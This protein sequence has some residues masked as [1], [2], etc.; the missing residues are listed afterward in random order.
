MVLHT[1]G[2]KL[3]TIINYYVFKSVFKSFLSLIA[4]NASLIQ[5]FFWVVMQSSTM[6]V[7]TLKP[8]MEKACA[9]R[10]SRCSLQ[11]IVHRWLLCLLYFIVN[12][13]AKIKY[14]HMF[15]TSFSISLWTC[16]ASSKY[17]FVLSSMIF[18]C[19]LKINLMSKL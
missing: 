16:S 6:S 9:I 1:V 13:L 3:L 4:Y 8:T 19:K 18:C 11:R 12:N 5:T 10:F 7:G 2:C 14:V 15:Q 17:S